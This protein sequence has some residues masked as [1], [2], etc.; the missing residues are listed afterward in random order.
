M[1]EFSVLLSDMQAVNKLHSAAEKR[2]YV[3]EIHS[4]NHIVPANSLV[5][6]FSFDLTKPVRV[7]SSK[8]NDLALKRELFDYICD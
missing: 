8:E 2:D 6:I 4:N 3:I 7:V 5:G 1:T